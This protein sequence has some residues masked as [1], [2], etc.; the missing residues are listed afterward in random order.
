LY[1]IG[2]SVLVCHWLG[3]A[4]CPKTRKWSL[5]TTPRTIQKGSKI[6][7]LGRFQL[8][9]LRLQKYEV[10]MNWQKI[11]DD[12]AKMLYFCTLFLKQ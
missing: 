11:V 2:P 9:E 8:I 1:T 3:V 4:W 12:M 7:F 6:G 5:R 10:F